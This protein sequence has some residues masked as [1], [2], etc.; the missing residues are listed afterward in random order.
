MSSQKSQKA[1]RKSS[2]NRKHY[3]KESP[4]RPEDTRGVV[5]IHNSAFKDNLSGSCVGKGLGTQ[6]STWD[7]GLRTEIEAVPKVGDDS[8]FQKQNGMRG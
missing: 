8:A 4:G 3:Q 6:A 5:H 2:R 7:L 1:E